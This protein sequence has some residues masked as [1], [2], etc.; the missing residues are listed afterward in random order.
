[1]DHVALQQAFELASQHHR[2]GRLPEAEQVYSQILAQQPQN[3]EAIH[4]LGLLAHQMGRSDAA[5]DLIRRAIALR[6]DFAEAHGNLGN[7]LKDGGQIDQAIAAYQQAVT[8][9]PN[10]AGVYSNLGNVLR[11]AGKFDEAIAAYRRAMAL[12]PG[13]AE[14]HYNLAIALKE[15]GQ[16]DDAIAAYRQ[17]IALR[18]NLAQA[19]SNLGIALRD[20]GQPD[21]AIVAF[22]QALALRPE[23]P[24]I[25]NN[26]GNVLRDMGQLD[27][28]IAAYRQAIALGPNVPKYHSNLVLALHYH[29]AS[30]ASAIAEEHRR[31]NLQHAPAREPVQVYANDPTPE[32]RL[33]IGYVS[34][35]FRDHVVGRNLLPLFR[36]HDRRH[37]EITCYAQAPFP[38]AMTGEFQRRADRWRSIGRMSDEQVAAQI[39]ADRIDIL[40]DLALHTAGNRLPVFALKAAPIQVTFAGY[41]GSTGLTTIDYRLSD[42]YLDPPGMDESIYSENT[43]RL[44]DSFWCYDPLDCRDIPVNALPA[45]DAGV[46]TFGCL[47]NFCKINDGVLALWAQVLEHVNNSRLLVLCPEGSHRQRMLERLSWEG[48]DPSRI[49]FATPRPRRAYLQLYHQID[50]CLDTF[51]YNGHTTGLDSFWMGVPVVTL[52]G[53]RAVSRAGWCQLSN[54]GLG[55]LAAQTPG[56][57]VSIA[58]KLADDLPRLQELRSTLRGRMERSPLMDAPKFARSIEAAY[59]QMWRTW[60]AQAAALR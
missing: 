12:M 47:N 35:D 31:W 7:A 15:K 2:A 4:G 41:P 28:A 29:P 32:R 53:Q 18:P 3:A 49:E 5:V 20:N 22:R 33:R 9:N 56:Q 19:H 13:R 34:P 48:I 39:R 59:R 58:V 21:E 52:V 45:R 14:V 42:P 57:F 55:E 50:L 1:M 40:V 8:L 10:F 25:H 46:V 36:Q 16:L 38:D 43:I 60:S 23:S 44:P 26:L 37:V 51:P 30:D 27:E 6:P 17:A 11:D 54:L 24:E